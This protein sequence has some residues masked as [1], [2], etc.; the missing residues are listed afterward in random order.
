MYLIV[1][2]S[3]AVLLSPNAKFQCL[4]RLYSLLMHSGFVQCF[5]ISAF[6][7]ALSFGIAIF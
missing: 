4:N 1:D 7:C 6:A 5:L 3:K 2:H